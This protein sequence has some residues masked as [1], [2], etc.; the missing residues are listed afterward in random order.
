MS[1]WVKYHDEALFHLLIF[2][3]SFSLQRKRGG[4]ANHSFHI[5]NQHQFYCESLDVFFGA[6]KALNLCQK[7]GWMLASAG[8]GGGGSLACAGGEQGRLGG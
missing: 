2:S 8:G 1:G 5:C 6:A 3:F 4:G 7:D